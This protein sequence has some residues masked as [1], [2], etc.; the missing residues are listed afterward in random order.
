[1]MRVGQAFIG[2]LTRYSTSA[3]CTHEKRLVHALHAVLSF[4]WL[5]VGILLAWFGYRCLLYEERRRVN[6]GLAAMS[7]VS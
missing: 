6:G 1:M 7:Q 3:H 2:E 4:W 5:A